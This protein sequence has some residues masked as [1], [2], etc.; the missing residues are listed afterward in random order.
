MLQSPPKNSFHVVSYPVLP[1]RAHARLGNI[2]APCSW[3][4]ANSNN[5]FTCAVQSSISTG[6][7]V[8]VPQIM[9]M[10]KETIVISRVTPITSSSFVT[11]LRT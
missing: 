9:G 4:K 10:M 1:S 7:G 6:L 2:I 5:S 8:H 3:L 11:G